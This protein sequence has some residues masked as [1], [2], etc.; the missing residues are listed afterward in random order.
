MTGPG[1]SVVAHGIHGRPPTHAELGGECGD[2]LAAGTDSAGD[3]G[4]CSFG[5]HRAFVDLVALIGE[6]RDGAVGVGAAPQ[7]LAPHEPDRHTRDRQ[8]AYDVAAGVVAPRSPAAARAADRGEGP[9]FDPQCPLP[10]Q[11]PAVRDHELVQ[12]D[13]RGCIATVILHQGPPW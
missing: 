13:E 3:V 10:A 6:G 12:S 4:A 2:G 7:L 8:V 1:A 5:E 9:A 11:Q